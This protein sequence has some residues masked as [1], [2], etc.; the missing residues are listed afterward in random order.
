MGQTLEQCGQ[1]GRNEAGK[2][3]RG[4][5]ICRE[6]G[7]TTAAN[8]VVLLMFFPWHAACC[9]QRGNWGRKVAAYPGVLS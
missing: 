9:I 1:I 7:A 3:C 5:I 4:G 2:F 8:A 6:I